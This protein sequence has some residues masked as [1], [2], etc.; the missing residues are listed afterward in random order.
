MARYL[1]SD[2]NSKV[3]YLKLINKT[4]GVLASLVKTLDRLLKSKTECYNYLSA[5]KGEIYDKYDINLD[6]YIIE[7]IN[8]EYNEEEV[9]QDK[10]YKLL[11]QKDL[12]ED[13]QDIIQLAKWCSILKN[14]VEV[15]KKLIVYKTI[16]NL[17][18]RDFQE[19][20]YNYYCKVHEILLNGNA[21]K[22]GNGIGTIYFKLIDTSPSLFKRKL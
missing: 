11:R 2:V 6:N 20:L 1:A 15:N 9:L 13:R 17:S 7:F 16:Y 21:Y 3:V 10:A 14:E 18:Y 19:Y 8:Q 5:R 4:R 22:L 12:E